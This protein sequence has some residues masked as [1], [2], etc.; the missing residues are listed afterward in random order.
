MLDNNEA[1]VFK[2]LYQIQ[3]KK[4]MDLEESHN[5]ICQEVEDLQNLVDELNTTNKDLKRQLGTTHVSV[6]KSS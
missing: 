2:K 1:L 6:E 3:E 4:I 5:W